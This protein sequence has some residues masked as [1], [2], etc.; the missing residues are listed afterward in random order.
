MKLLR[1]EDMP[2]KLRT[3]FHVVH[4]DPSGDYNMGLDSVCGDDIPIYF[5]VLLIEDM[6]N[7]LGVSSDKED[8][9]NWLSWGDFSDNFYK[10]LCRSK[11]RLELFKT[12][13]CHIEQREHFK[14][15]ILGGMAERGT[16]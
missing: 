4:K 5:V 16:W 9:K 14:D 7:R 13:C 3:W 8:K 2:K 1:F 11:A 6:L 10:W 15:T 12:N